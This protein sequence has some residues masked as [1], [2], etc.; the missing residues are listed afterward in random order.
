MIAALVRFSV[1]RAG[2]VVALA[3][4]LLGLALAQLGP[5]RKEVVGG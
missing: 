2:L 3:L 1:R 5:R 4:A